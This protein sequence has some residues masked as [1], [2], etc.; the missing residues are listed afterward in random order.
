MTHLTGNPHDG[1]LA[2]MSTAEHLDSEDPT[3]PDVGSFVESRLNR[4]QV[5]AKLGVAVKTVDRIVKDREIGHYRLGSRIW[6]SPHH[7]AEY[8]ASRE[9][10]RSA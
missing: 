5:A 8:L 7:V 3:L 9:V 2:D 10:K 6:F 1:E 4:K